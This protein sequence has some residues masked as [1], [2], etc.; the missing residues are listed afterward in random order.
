MTGTTSNAARPRDVSVLTIDPE[1][2]PPA[3]YPDVPPT[4]SFMVNTR[5]PLESPCAA[6]QH[7]GIGPVNVVAGADWARANA[8]GHEPGGERARPIRCH[9]RSVD[10]FVISANP[11]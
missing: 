2:W 11:R 3:Y 6:F 4:D 8:C 5:M 10:T 1:G 7:R 9:K